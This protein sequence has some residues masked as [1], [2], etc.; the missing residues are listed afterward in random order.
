MKIKPIMPTK[1]KSA[2]GNIQ[3]EIGIMTPAKP[4]LFLWFSILSLISF[5][6]I[7]YVVI[8][9]IRPSIINFVVTRQEADTVVFANRLANNLLLDSDF[10][11]S[12]STETGERL[13]IF[14][15]GLQIPAR[16]AV[17]ITD[18]EGIILAS[19][20]GEQ[21]GKKINTNAEFNRAKRELRS[22]AFFRTLSPSEKEQVGAAEVFELYIP[23]TFGISPQV[24]GVVHALSRTGFIR[25]TVRSIEEDIAMRIGAG[26]VF[27]YVVI[28]IIVWWASKTIRRQA[29]ALSDYAVTLESKVRARTRELQAVFGSVAEGIVV[30]NKDFRVVLMNKSAETILGTK[31]SEVIGQKWTDLVSMYRGKKEMPHEEWATSNVLKTSSVKIFTVA[32]NISYKLKDGQMVPVLII[33]SPLVEEKNIEGVVLMFRDVREERKLE[34][35]RV[36]F[37]SLASHQLRTPIVSILWLTELLQRKTEDPL[38]KRKEFIDDIYTMAL[39]MRDLLNLLLQIGRLESKRLKIEPVN[40][41]IEDIINSTLLVLQSQIDRKKQTIEMHILPDPFP[42]VALDKIVLGQVLQNIISNS[43]SYSLEGQKIKISV[44]I[45]K[46]MILCAIQDEGIGIPKNQQNRIYEKF[47]RADNAMRMVPVGN[48][49]GLSFVKSLVAEFGGETWFESEEGKGSTFYFSIPS[50]GMKAKEGEVNLIV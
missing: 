19:D 49:L 26:F 4:H 9:A 20:I 34:D 29:G 25:E 44:S 36:S 11:Y 17:D 33:A 38:P 16:I 48:G 31:E 46:N 7:G 14:L 23:I 18:H 12:T 28:A 50:S 3:Q 30:I 2:S 39:R 47:F 41:K 5:I 35:A 42:I 27:L 32:D 6:L 45:N 15:Q 1:V 21:V 40:A 22:Q 13:S 24:A 8:S 10:Q 37:I 43:I